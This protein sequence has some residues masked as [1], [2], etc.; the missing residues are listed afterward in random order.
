[1]EIVKNENKFSK[2]AEMV[3]THLEAALAASNSGQLSLEVC[4]VTVIV[5]KKSTTICTTIERYGIR[6]TYSARYCPLILLK[7]QNILVR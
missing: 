1:M 3:S 6:G 5:N 4:D 2:S 7:R